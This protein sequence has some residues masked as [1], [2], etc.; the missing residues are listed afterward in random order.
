M[1]NKRTATGAVDGVLILLLTTLVVVGALMFSS[2][3]F[4]LIARGTLSATSVF[5]N[6]LGLG[7][8]LGIVALL[9]TAS[10]DISVWRRFIPYVY[11]AAVLLTAL[12][13]IPHIGLLHGGGKR[14]IVLFHVSIQPSEFLKIATIMLAA[15]YCVMMKNK[16]QT[17]RYGLGGLV[18]VLAL[19]GALLLAQP[20]LGT[21]GVICIAVLAIFWIAGART[22]HLTLLVVG[23]VC[24]ILLLALVRPYVR[25]RIETFI[26][27][28]DGQQAQ[29]YQLKQALIAI[30]SGEFFGRGFGQGIQKFTYLPE[31]MG[32]SIFAV[33]GEEFGFVGSATLVLLFL[34]FALRGYLVSLRN[35]DLFARYTGVGITTYFIFEA[36]INIS[37]MLGIAPLTGIPLTFISQGGSAMLVSLASAGILLRISRV[38]TARTI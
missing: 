36:F 24:A 31:P 1:T 28:A 4:G 5:L 25:D 27:P 30:G 19:P 14:W 7:V 37:S 20:D 10:I 29:S 26:H 8:G 38:R 21:L 15:S 18:G 22:S 2:A 9:I 34:C 35:S 33:L 32:D 6:H 3:A 23:G 17:I 12:V 13:F 16:I 11:G